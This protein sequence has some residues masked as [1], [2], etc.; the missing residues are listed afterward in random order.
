MTSST[1]AA[2]SGADAA[3]PGARSGS[4]SPRSP[5]PSVPAMAP[6]TTETHMPLTTVDEL[7]ASVPLLQ[8]L[9]PECLRLVAGCASTDVFAVNEYVARGGAPADTFY[10][11]REGRAV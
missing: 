11:I 1:P 5:P 10:A 2:V 9:P 6:S 3:S 7:T 8:H 4:T